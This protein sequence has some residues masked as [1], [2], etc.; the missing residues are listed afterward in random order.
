MH[1]VNKRLKR[2]QK[3]N[4]PKAR[5]HTTVFPTWRKEISMKS[6]ATNA[7]EALLNKGTHQ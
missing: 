6:F 7:N 1:N 3:N 2:E 5:F 4:A